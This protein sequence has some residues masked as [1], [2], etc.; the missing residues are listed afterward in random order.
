M[1]GDGESRL[2]PRIIWGEERGQNRTKGVEG[3]R[4]RKS[5]MEMKPVVMGEEKDEHCSV[6]RRIDNSTKNIFCND[7]QQ[8]TSVGEKS[9]A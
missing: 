2:S 6:T 9:D 7:F 5:V 4:E 8:K 3:K 1:E